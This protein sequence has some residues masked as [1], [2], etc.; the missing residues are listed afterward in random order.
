VRHHRRFKP[1]LRAH[2]ALIAG[3][4]AAL[5][6][7]AGCSEGPAPA[8]TTLPPAHALEPAGPTAT[9]LPSNP[10]DYVTSSQR[11]T[12]NGRSG[13]LI[14]T[15]HYR[16]FTTMDNGETIVKMPMF[17]E[18]AVHHYSRALAPLGLPTATMETYMMR[19]KNQWKSLTS[20]FLG[21]DAG[22]AL[23][24]PR[25]G[26]AYNGKA[27]LYDI[28]PQDTFAISAHEGWHQYTQRLFKEGLPIWLEEGIATYMEGFKW[29]VEDKNLPHFLG[30]ANLQ[31]YQALRNYAQQGRLYSL[32]RLLNTSPATLMDGSGDDSLVY[33]A[34]VWG[35]V[36]F[37]REGEGGKYAAGLASVLQDAKGGRISARVGGTLGER[38]ASAFRLR[39][40]GAEVFQTYFNQDL[41]TAQREYTAFVQGATA[42]GT[43]NA[44]GNG[45]SPLVR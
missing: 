38:A 41:A 4:I 40:N 5:L 34:Q 18:Q 42:T 39:R 36:H 35:L 3:L 17:L 26:F 45:T 20:R 37:L 24:I 28:G 30:W 32:E 2:A 21:D 29:D 31:R 9:V 10:G 15:H 6:G 7:V 44:I 27:L 23:K 11:W 8:P 14:T 16:I 12:F 43:Q 1:A 13:K 33:Y 25:G 19:D 22:V